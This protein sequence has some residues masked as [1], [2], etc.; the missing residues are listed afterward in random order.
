MKVSI[1]TVCYN[2]A[3]TIRDTI[4]SVINQVYPDIEYIIIDGCSN[5]GTID[6]VKSYG[7]KISAFISEPDNGIYDAM[8]KGICIATG[9]IVGILNSDDFYIN[10]HV[11]SNIVNLF[12]K[13]NA[14]TLFADLVYVKHKKTD[15]IVRY[16]SGSTF[17]LNAF[18]WGTYIPFPTFFVKRQ[19]YLKYGMYKTD[20]VI[21][22]DFELVARLL[23][24]GKVSYAYFPEVIVKMRMGGVST[25]N[26]KSYFI[27]NNEILRAC[28]NNNIN[29][30]IIK[31]YFKYFKKG[32]QLLSRPKNSNIF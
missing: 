5:D 26:Y 6:I 32:L 24:C 7:N 18:A 15:R 30:N 25:R 10:Q 21:A 31:I 9:D 2:S 8:N 22:A 1:V 27:S 28:A 13:S 12:K 17:N 19:L 4:H 16:Y 20:Y 14:D 3:K 23:Y 29:T 11:I